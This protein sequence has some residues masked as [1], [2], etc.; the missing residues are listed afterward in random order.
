[1][2]FIIP[3][4][5]LS[6]LIACILAVFITFHIVVDIK[7]IIHSKKLHRNLMVIATKHSAKTISVVIQLSKS[8][9][10]IIPL[11]NH[12]YG[13]K[14]PGLEVIII[15]NST[16]KNSNKLLIK[17]RR[18]NKIKQLK[19]INFKKDWKIRDYLRRYGTGKLAMI[20]TDE[21]RLSKDFFTNASIE[22]ISNNKA[23][24][25]LPRQHTSLNRT[26]VSALM[27]NVNNFR[28]LFQLSKMRTSVMPLRP[29]LIY[30]RKL[31]LS[32]RKTTV[33]LLP[34]SQQL[35]VSNIS[36]VSSIKNYLQ[37][38]VLDTSR[39]LKSRYGSL[40]S[41]FLAF[42]IILCFALLNSS[43]ILFLAVFII[44]LYTLTIL[45]MQF[46]FK[47]YSLTE[48]TCLVLISPFNILAKIVIFF[49]VFVRLIILSTIKFR[50]FLKLR[51]LPN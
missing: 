44:A 43:E 11:I 28:Q 41:F 20:L 49:C 2:D 15:N 4:S 26:I 1:M 8:P 23:I 12:L 30:N 10:T 27:A 22:S 24:A 21:M 25:V 40:M 34:I 16:S 13:H 37:Q 5:K 39:T 6:I 38:S 46:Y 29:G 35:Y 45:L 3:T 50:L 17:Y 48:R 18:D 36:N 33:I 7:E 51:L 19:I 9:D 47:G 32:N 14:Y 42:I 31:I